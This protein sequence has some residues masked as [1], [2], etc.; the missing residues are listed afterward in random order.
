LDE[1]SCQNGEIPVGDIAGLDN[2]RFET[3][4]LVTQVTEHVDRNSRLMAFVT[5]EDRLDQVDVTVFHDYYPRDLQVGRP[6]RVH[7]W[8][9]GRGPKADGFEILDLAPVAV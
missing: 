8:V 3:I 9:D 6:Y 4:C 5:I 7:G 2:S 1:F